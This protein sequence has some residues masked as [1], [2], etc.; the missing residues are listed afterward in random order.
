MMTTLNRD[1]HDSIYDIAIGRIAAYK[2]Y[3]HNRVYRRLSIHCQIQQMQ[4]L[5]NQFPDPS[6][7]GNN[8]SVL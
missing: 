7:T 6:R 5:I 1:F 4:F 2:K 3:G 8:F